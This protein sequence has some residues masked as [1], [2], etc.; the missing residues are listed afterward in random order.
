MEDEVQEEVKLGVADITL[1]A[2]N[3]TGEDV[4][5]YNCKSEYLYMQSSGECAWCPACGTSHVLAKDQTE[6]KVFIPNPKHF[7]P[8]EVH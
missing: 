5:C 2:E 3:F 4:H 7:T 8:L 1:K 6:V